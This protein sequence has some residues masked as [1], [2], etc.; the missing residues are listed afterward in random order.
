MQR[1]GRVSPVIVVS[2]ALVFGVGLTMC[3]QAQTVSNLTTFDGSNGH[4]PLGTL[5]QATDGNLYG[6]TFTGGT[7]D[8]GTVFQVTPSGQLKTIYSFCSQPKCADGQYSIS[9]PVLGSDGNLYGVVSSGGSYAGSMTGSG[10]VYKMTTGGKITILYTFCSTAP[11]NDG[12]TPN[13]VTLGYDG[14]FYGTTYRGGQFNSGTIFSITSTGKFTVLYSF[15]SQK[16]CSDGWSPQLP[17]IQGT[18]GNF[19][20]V[21]L[22]GG[23]LGDGVAYKLTPSGTYTVLHNFCYGSGCN[24][25]QANQLV[26]DVKGN[27]FGTTVM[28]GSSAKGSKTGYGTVFEITSKNQY[29]VLH[30]FDYTQGSP[31][32]G[33]ALANDGNLYGTS[34]GGY[35]SIQNGGTL[36]EITPAGKYTQLYT[37]SVCGVTGYLPSPGLV[38]GSD[39]IF[40][41]STIY[42]GGSSCAD[43]GSLYTLSNGLIPMVKIV[44]AGGKVG[45]SVIILGNALKGSTSVTFNGKPATFTVVSNTEIKATVP[46]GATTGT[47]S[48]VTPTGTLKSNPQFVVAK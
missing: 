44:P 27:L 6:A 28:G 10:T 41:G 23:S 13:G 7:K 45:Q 37:F 33:F 14:N 16:N 18:D 39:G 8:S 24:G 34:A 5:A 36:F 3:A 31:G 9:S 46:S 48:V 43:D 12:Q 22:N 4:D 42:G 35:D 19:Y 21:A 25:S 29:L 11:C 20:G 32:A 30:N 2:L 17:P 40:Y 47:V 38:Q 1:K 15:C 26:Q